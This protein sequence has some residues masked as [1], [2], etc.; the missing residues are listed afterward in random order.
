MALRA[1]QNRVVMWGLLIFV[2]V[3]GTTIEDMV[4]HKCHTNSAQCY[5]I[6]NACFL[7]IV[8]I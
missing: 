2:G 1:H 3:G 7:I 5:L 8:T 6:H 4:A